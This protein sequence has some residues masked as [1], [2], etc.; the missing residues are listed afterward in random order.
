[1]SNLNENL[2]SHDLRDMIHPIISIDEFQPKLDEDNI[3]VCLQVKDSYDAAYDLSSFL[4]KCPVEILD[5]EAPETPNLDGMYNVF[6]EFKRDIEF[7]D[8]FNDLITDLERIGN[9]QPWKVQAYKINDPFDYTIEQ[10][11]D[12]VRL[13]KKDSLVEF[14]TESRLHPTYRESYII[15][16]SKYQ[17]NSDCFVYESA[18]A[19]TQDDVEYAIN[20][21]KYQ[22]D[23]SRLEPALGDG[24]TV[25]K[26]YDGWIVHNGTSYILLR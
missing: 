26:A 19:I 23:E 4:E 17:P 10:V 16:K 18:M 11:Q 1:M 13:V 5:T 9:K 24:F 21:G 15:L 7:P 2:L 20:S 3:V 25:L 14:F 8:K 6:I 12:T 22:L